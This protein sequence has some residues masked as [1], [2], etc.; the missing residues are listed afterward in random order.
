MCKFDKQE[1]T[2]P[3]Y[4]ENEEYQ[5]EKYEDEEYQ[6]EDFSYTYTYKY[7]YTYEKL[8]EIFY[9]KLEEKQ[10]KQKNDD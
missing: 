1:T 3:K 4:S 7:T 9:K 5:D 10:N 8:A 6:D 2:K